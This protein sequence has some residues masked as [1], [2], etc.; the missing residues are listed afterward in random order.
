MLS[1]MLS[2]LPLW[3]L[4]ALCGGLVWLLRVAGWRRRLVVDGLSLCLPGRDAAELGRHVREFYEGLGR[5]VAEFVYEARMPVAEFEE[6]LRFEDD[7]VVRDALAQGRRVLL[8]A[9]HHCNW[10]WLHL[11]CSRRF[12]VQAVAPYKPIS[13][14]GPD[15]WVLGMRRRFGAVMVPAGEIGPY[16]VA[17]RRQ[18][19]LIA[20]L[21]DQSPAARSDKQVWLP[22]LGRDTSFFQGPGWVG[23]RLRFEP[24]FIAMRPEGRGRYVARFV[25][26]AAPGEHLDAGQILRRY[27]GAL[28]EQVRRYP[29]GYF[30]AYNR[31]K[32]PRQPHE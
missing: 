12:G 24:V 11:E 22:F 2:L 4:Y 32:R 5:L 16:L 10:E 7:A 23:E 21:A 6:R 1:R 9:G 28:E 14:A 20:M 18:V 30:W 19:R 29:A 26:L 13:R 8:V 31:W 25:P 27:V 3:F 17:R 15:N